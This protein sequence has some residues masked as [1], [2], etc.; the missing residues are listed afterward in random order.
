MGRFGG[1]AVALVLFAALAVALLWPA[2]PGGGKV[3]AADDLILFVPPFDS[4]RPADATRP[5]NFYHSDSV[6]VFHPDQLF[7]REQIRSFDLPVWNPLTGAGQPLLAQQQ[8]APLY[9]GTLLT[10]LLPYWESLGLVALIKLVLAALG[11]YLL[12]RAFGLARP[13]AL[14]S[15]IAFTF[16]T[17][18]VSWLEHPH[19]NAYI[20][21]PWLLLLVERVMRRGRPGDALALGGVG[22]LALL[23]GH[24]Q[25]ALISALPAIGL[26]VWLL[27]DRPGRDAPSRG[28]AVALLAGA[29]LLSLLVGAVM[30]LPFAE[31]LTQAYNS[32]R[33]GGTAEWRVL[34]GMFFPEFW[35]RPDKFLIDGGPLNYPERTAYVGMVPLALAAAGLVARRPS[36][37]Q[38]FVLVVGIAS[39]LAV[40]DTPLWSGFVREVPGLASIAL[41]RLMIVVSFCAAMLAGFGLQRLLDGDVRERKRM[42]AAFVGFALLAPGF[43]ALQQGVPFGELGAA[44]RELPELG[45]E[46][47]LPEVVQMSAVLRWGVLALLGTALLA[48]AIRSPRFVP[49]LAVA[50]IVIA[51]AE[52][53]TLNRGYNPAVDKSLVEPRVPGSVSFVQRSQGA[54]RMAADAE[55]FGPNVA[56]RYWIRDARTHGLPVIERYSS[57]WLALGGSGFQRTTLRPDAAAAP[58]ALDLLGVTHVFSPALAASPGAPV[59]FEGEGGPVVGNPDALPRAYVA[60]GWRS[61]DDAATA[62][63][64]LALR[65]PGAVQNEPLVEGLGGR[66]SDAP[67]TPALITR[68]E[69]T[70][71]S[72]ELEAE[73]PGLLLLHDNYYPGWRAYVDG[74]QADVHPANVAFRAV[75]VPA[76]RHEVRFAYEPASVRVGAVLSALGL[77]ALA[78]GVVALVLRRRRRPRA[79]L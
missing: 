79:S 12:G 35:G 39:F 19:S 27:A 51:A 17:Y 71:V 7:A 26:A 63:A 77:L 56:S 38:V 9:P 8:T 58:R 25:S 43:W 36:R 65:E 18:M 29:T 24:P 59:E 47:R 69:S 53:V 54:G 31:V 49:W 41:T 67:A 21:L 70:E 62:A 52:L 1:G 20:L 50:A 42:L 46:P 4:V 2:L 23:A 28:R 22:G 60:Y 44:L 13:A 78:G 5:S 66:T 11:T 72:V 37:A 76:G 34:Y 10:F 74:E 73:R 55:T 40:V 57:L 61:V 16:G 6:F 15:G 3:M 14:L 32:D 30:L 75:E 45:V 33:G 68:D 64:E 48:L